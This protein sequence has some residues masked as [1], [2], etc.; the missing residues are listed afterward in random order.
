MRNFVS[1]AVAFVAV[2]GALI[3]LGA[4]V[5]AWVAYVGITVVIVG[6]LLF[7]AIARRRTRR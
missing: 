2:S 5:Q 6:G 7:Q 1:W 3:V 4:S